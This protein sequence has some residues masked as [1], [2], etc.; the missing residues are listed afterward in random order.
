MS[1]VKE[2]PKCKTIIDV[3]YEETAIECP[4]C[5]TTVN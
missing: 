1:N 2:C 4:I 3:D 5:N